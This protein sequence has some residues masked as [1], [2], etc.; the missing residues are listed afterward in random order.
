MLIELRFAIKVLGWSKII[1]LFNAKR[2]KIEE[3]PFD[4]NHNRLTSYNPDG[5]DEKICF[6]RLFIVM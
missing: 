2:G 6:Q 4:I 1:C 5:I 3:L